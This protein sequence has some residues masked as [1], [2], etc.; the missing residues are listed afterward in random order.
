MNVNSITSLTRSSIHTW[1]RIHWFFGSIQTPIEWVVAI[2]CYSWVWI[3]P[4]SLSLLSRPFYQTAPCGWSYHSNQILDLITT[5]ANVEDRLE[6]RRNIKKPIAVTT[7]FKHIHS[8]I[9]ADQSIKLQWNRGELLSL[10]LY[11]LSIF[12]RVRYVTW[13]YWLSIKP[14]A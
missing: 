14:P 7:W 1:Q 4:V 9:Y 2:E 8:L 10:V 12:R 3:I 6:Y 5:L 11:S 13:M